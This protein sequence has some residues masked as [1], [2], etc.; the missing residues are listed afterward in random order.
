MKFS[1]SLFHHLSISDILLIHYR[2]LYSHQTCILLI[3][4][5]CDFF[6]LIWCLCQS[7]LINFIIFNLTTI[8]ACLYY[9][10]YC[11]YWLIRTKRIN[12]DLF[13]IVVCI[14]AIFHERMIWYQLYVSHYYW[15]RN[16][17]AAQS[18]WSINKYSA[19]KLLSTKMNFAWFSKYQC[20]AS[21]YCILES[22]MINVYIDDR[23]I[24]HTCDSFELRFFSSLL[25]LPSWFFSRYK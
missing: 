19:K 2:W 14:L 11:M 8:V 4:T 22:I 6:W 12:L 13:I 25:E 17:F 24:I 16:L 21:G 15:I 5:Y 10:L 9:A 20:V 3:F 7:W 1:I 23:T 18:N